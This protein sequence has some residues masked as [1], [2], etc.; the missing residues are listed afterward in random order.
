MEIS[1]VTLTFDYE[2]IVLKCQ[3]PLRFQQQSSTT[4][5]KKNCVDA[6]N[7]LICISWAVEDLF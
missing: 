1:D 4:K 2:E 3:V 6:E 5:K 7:W